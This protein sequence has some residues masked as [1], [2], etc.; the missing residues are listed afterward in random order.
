MQMSAACQPPIQSSY[1]AADQAHPRFPEYLRY[2]ASMSSLL[3]TGDDFR[4][5]LRQT[6]ERERSFEVVFNVN[7]HDTPWYE[8]PEG[9]LNN[10][11]YKHRFAPGHKLIERCGPFDTKEEADAS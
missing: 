6:E 2:R 1:S 5:W 4:G 9:A 8:R 11:W 10:G 3:V 7:W